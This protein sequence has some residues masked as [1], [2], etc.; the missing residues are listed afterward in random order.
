MPKIECNHGNDITLTDANGKV[1]L[2][3]CQLEG[4]LEVNIS[5]AKGIGINL[6]DD[7]TA[8]LEWAYVKTD[9]GTARIHGML[10]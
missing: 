9:E 7:G 2:T 6:F 5:S 8:Q 3:T 1:L 10:E 4:V